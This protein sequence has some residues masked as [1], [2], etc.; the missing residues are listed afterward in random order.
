MQR[1]SSAAQAERRGLLRV[2]FVWDREMPAHASLDRLL[3]PMI[4]RRAVEK[5]AGTLSALAMRAK[6][7]WGY[8]AQ[9]LEP[10]LSICGAARCDAALFLRRF[11][12]KSSSDSPEQ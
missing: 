6:A 12:R 8:S 2:L 7:H 11:A 9:A 5:E 1:L 4:I 3:P 10:R